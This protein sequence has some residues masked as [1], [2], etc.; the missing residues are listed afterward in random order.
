LNRCGRLE[1]IDGT[2]IQPKTKAFG[3]P[4]KTDRISGR[5]ASLA[6]AVTSR[7]ASDA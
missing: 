4:S 6:H 1:L 2:S 5:S 3:L 7:A